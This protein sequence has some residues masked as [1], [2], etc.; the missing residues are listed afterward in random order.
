MVL[1]FMLS[2]NDLG[3]Q[4]A[5]Y[6]FFLINRLRFNWLIVSIWDF[7]RRLSLRMVMKQSLDK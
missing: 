6:F 7:E 3:C 5:D 1:G 4:E 2:V